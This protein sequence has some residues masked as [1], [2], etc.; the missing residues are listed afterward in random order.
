MH[1]NK[2]TY[3]DIAKRVAQGYTKGFS[4]DEEDQIVIWELTI[5]LDR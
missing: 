3:E 5:K 4:C 2:K 1:P